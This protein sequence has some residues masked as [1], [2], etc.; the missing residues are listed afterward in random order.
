MV[1]C[2][3]ACSLL[4]GQME[5]KWKENSWRVSVSV[6]DGKYTGMRVVEKQYLN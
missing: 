3:V 6:I 1:T 5:F 4:R 2:Y